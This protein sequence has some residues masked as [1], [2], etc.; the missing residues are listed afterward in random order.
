[1]ATHLDAGRLGEQ[2]ASTYLLEHG[3]TMLAMNWRYRHWEVDIIAMDAQTLCFVEVKT[4]KNNVFGE[5]A[6]FVDHKKQQNLIQAADAYMAL[7][8]YEG[9]IRFDIV[10]VYLETNT[11]ELIKDAFWSN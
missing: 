8:H 1:M 5:A 3:Y 4:R 11:I 7:N 2:Q 10:S 9:E 6:D